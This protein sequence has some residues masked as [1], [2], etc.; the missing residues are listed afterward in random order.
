MKYLFVFLGLSLSCFAAN[1]VSVAPDRMLV[2][3]GQPTFVLGLYENPTDDA[4]LDEAAKAGFNLIQ[5]PADTGQLDRLHNRGVYAWINVGAS[6][7]LSTDA[8][9]RKTA[10]KK[11][12]DDYADHESLLVWE[13]PDEALWNVWYGAELWRNRDEPKQQDELIAALEDKAK[14]EKLRA[15]RA[16][17]GK[18]RSIAEY[19]QAEQ[20][21]DSIWRE[22]GKEPPHPPLNTSNAPE[23]AATMAA[24]ML[25]GYNYLKK[26]C[27]RHPVWMNHAPRNSVAQRAVFNK[28]ADAVGCD[29]YPVPPQ[30]G[31]HSDLADRGLTSVGAFTRLMQDAAPGKPVWMVLQSFSWAELAEKKGSPD[32]DQQR[33][34]SFN[35]TRFMAYDTIVN[36]ARGI[37]YWGSAYTDKS[38]PFWGDLLKVV[39]ELADLQPVL[40]APDA[41]VSVNVALD[42]TW[43]SLDQGIR[44]L[45]KQAPDGIWL[46]A[47]NEWHDPLR[48]TV[49][50]LKES[51]NLT[52]TDTATGISTTVKN[53]A[54]GLNIASYG[55]QVL[56]PRN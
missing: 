23:R 43:G 9:T 3:N 5:S 34:P 1:D 41:D 18:H 29:I 7:D 10:L 2:V 46:I 40:S 24:G 15:M 11:L 13:V 44:V 45:P 26:I 14:A 54:F 6:I 50:G 25:E 47:V 4:V 21:A 39:R 53:G 35:E 42:E 27:P 55:T 56:R 8:D 49:N 52:Y 37:L 17:V 48:Y 51:E 19:N 20:L 12:A 31:G 16:D 36:G 38:K 33:H 30:I 22:L 32:L 28:A